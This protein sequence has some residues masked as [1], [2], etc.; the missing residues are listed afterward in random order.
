MMYALVDCNN[1]YVSCERLFRPDLKNRPVLVLSNNDG[2]VISRSDEVKA[3][4]IHV[5]VPVYQ[6]E[7]II[8][9][10]NI[11]VFS[12]NYPLYGDMSSRVMG[13]L[14]EWSPEIEIYSIDEAFLR[15]PEF[16]F[17]DLQKYAEAMRSKV[18]KGTGIPIS[19]GFAPTKALAKV[20]DIIAKKFPE[21]TGYVYVIDTEEK[22]L[23]ALKWMAIE[24]VWGIGHRHARRLKL[25][26]VNTAYDFT[27]LP[28]DWVKKNLSVVGLR[29]KHDLEGKPT[30]DLEKAKPRKN[31]AV[32]R[33]FERDYF[34]FEELKER[35]AT[36]A[37]TCAEKLRKQNS[38][39]AALYVFVYT[40][41]HRDEEPQYKPHVVVKLPFPTNSGIEL[42]K[43][44]IEGLGRIY[45]EGYRY[46]K[47]GVVVM[48]ITPEDKRQITLFENSD[49]RHHELMKAVDYLNKYIGDHKVKLATQDLNRT[50]KMKQNNLSPRYTTRISDIPVIHI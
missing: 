38:H 32:T 29:L 12:S 35:V 50:W 4:D 42:A 40:N 21:K 18:S 20:A 17:D 2:C 16:R 13:M 26:N 27:Q 44:A 46:K 31:I 6:V 22:R 3:L 15:F 43:F 23:K 36:F 19:V 45:R 28:D 39:C 9:A 34:E 33:S 7:K 14:A 37:V 8:A 47:A 5:G 41:K 25:M 48:N 30:L 24:R 11:H 10:H 49:P 1:F